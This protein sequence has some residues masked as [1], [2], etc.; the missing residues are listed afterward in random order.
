ME[1][2]LGD[3]FVF[4]ELEDNVNLLLSGVRESFDPLLNGGLAPLAPC[5][6]LVVVKCLS[7]GV[8]NGGCGMWWSGSW[9]C[10]C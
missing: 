7:G 5:H 10:E 2:L 4:Q 9:R 3:A 8:E 1:L 6:W